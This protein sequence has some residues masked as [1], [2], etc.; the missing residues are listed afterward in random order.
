MEVRAERLELLRK[1]E[2]KVYLNIER[3]EA[4]DKCLKELSWKILALN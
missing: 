3:H 4:A 1:E 2:R